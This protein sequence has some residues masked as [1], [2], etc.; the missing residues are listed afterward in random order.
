MYPFGLMGKKEKGFDN[1]GRMRFS[2]TT[3]YALRVMVA[4][5]S[6]KEDR[7]SLQTLAVREEIPRKFLEHVVRSLKDAELVQSTPGPKGGYQLCRPASTIT[8]GE[9]LRAIQG[10]LMPFDRMET[11]H[12]PD[13]LRDPVDRLRI[14]I[15]DIRVF[16]R[17]KLES[18]TLADLAQVK[19]AGHHHEA[20]MYYI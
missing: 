1:E 16:A 10:P 19:Q 7:L 11:N 9:I 13:H 4:L 2:K 15:S 17:H 8:L 5:A 3:D 14:I 6:A 20:L 18:V 12:L